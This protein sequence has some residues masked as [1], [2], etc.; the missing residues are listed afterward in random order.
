MSNLHTYPRHDD[1]AWTDLD[2]PP[3]VELDTVRLQRIWSAWFTLTPTVGGP[4][5][6]E[7][8]PLLLALLRDHTREVVPY[9]SLILQGDARS[10]LVR[11][12]RNDAFLGQSPAQVAEQTGLEAWRFLSDQVAAWADQSVSRRAVLLRLLTQLGFYNLACELAEKEP[13]LADPA[14]D[15]LD[16]EIARA[17]RQHLRGTETPADTF[18]RVA[19]G[20]RVPSLRV[21]ASTQLISILLRDRDGERGSGYWTSYGEALLPLLSEEAPWVRELTLSRYWR[22][23][24]FHQIAGKDVEAARAAMEAA[25]TAG[26]E[27]E[28]L[29]A[30]S[31]QWH[32]AV[33]NTRLLMDVTVKAGPAVFTTDRLGAAARRLLDLDGNEPSARFFVA[34]WRQRQG[35]LQ[36]AAVEFERGAQLGALRGPGCAY[37]AVQCYQELGDEEAAD[38]A[39]RL[40]LELDPA[41]EVPKRAAR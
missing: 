32:A 33:E 9:C 2:F 21:L 39:T 35:D 25:V 1:I 40:L 8:T 19:T 5:C 28:R 15:H 13:G 4:L 18:A 11:Q 41:A 23:A 20:G 31:Q 38:R 6:A 34:A 22:A 27:A 37:R 26:D 3:P 30:T 24:A 14:R 12:A 10:W 7:S 36:G 16:Y 29:A 17:L